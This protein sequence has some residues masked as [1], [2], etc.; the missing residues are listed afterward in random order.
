MSPDELY[1]K[2]ARH[3]SY[4]E[5][6][7]RS[8][9]PIEASTGGEGS[10]SSKRRTVSMEDEEDEEA[11]NMDFGNEEEDDRF[12]GDGLTS[13]QKDILD[14]VDEINPEEVCILALAY[15]GMLSDLCA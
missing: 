11:G 9:D 3:A 13:D 12:F 10:S 15:L 14:Y 7:G 5:L 8:F 4:E 2:N 6:T 1:R